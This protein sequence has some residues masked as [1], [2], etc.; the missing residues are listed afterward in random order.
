MDEE[1]R[2]FAAQFKEIV[3]CAD[4]QDTAALEVVEQL[5]RLHG[6]VERAQALETLTT[7]DTG[8]SK[9]DEEEE[10]EEQAAVPEDALTCLR[11]FP[12]LEQRLRLCHARS[13][14]AQHARITTAWDKVVEALNDMV[15]VEAD[16]QA[17]FTQLCKEHSVSEMEERGTA[18]ASVAE[19]VMGAQDVTAYTRTVVHTNQQLLDNIRASQRSVASIEKATDEWATLPPQCVTTMRALSFDPSTVIFRISELDDIL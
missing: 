1:R 18:H 6:M 8:N 19:F 4:R 13:A 2:A 10:Q 17:S 9:G 12:N 14:E 3:S 7:S 16:I 5:Q 11:K 15:R